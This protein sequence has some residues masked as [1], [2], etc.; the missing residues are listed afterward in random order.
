ML[1]LK[2]LPLRTDGPGDH[3]KRELVDDSDRFFRIALG[4]RPM[5]VRFSADERRVFVANYLNNSVQIVNLAERQVERTIAL[6]GPANASL[7]ARRS[8]FL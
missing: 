6:G 8:D 3:M 2:D 5:A 1:S 7:A 4:G